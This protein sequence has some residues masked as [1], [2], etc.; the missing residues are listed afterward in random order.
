[1]TSLNSGKLAGLAAKAIAV[2]ALAGAA[3]SASA[4]VLVFNGDT[5]GDPVW[6]RTLSGIPPTGLSGVGTAVHYEISRFNVSANGSYSL[7]NLSSYD[8][9]LNLYHTAFSPTSQFVNV[10]GA[11]DDGGGG[12][13]SLLSLNLMAGVDYY[14]VSSGF[15]NTDFGAFTLTIRGDGDIFDGGS[16]NVPEP[17]SLALAGVALLGLSL[18]RRRKAR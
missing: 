15:A 17:A 13:N 10:I 16:N 4:G 6:N 18:A 7:L 8:N 14:A 12:L 1:M 11:N 5:T 9:Y 3:A 2:L